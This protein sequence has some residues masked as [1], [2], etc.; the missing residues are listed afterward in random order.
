[1]RERKPGLLDSSGA[2]GECNSNSGRAFLSRVPDQLAAYSA[3]R[4]EFGSVRA[5][6]RAG[7]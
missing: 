4:R 2:G 5:A 6:V 1:M 7:R 3:R